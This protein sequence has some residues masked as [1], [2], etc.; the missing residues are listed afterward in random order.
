M[1]HVLKMKDGKLL[2]P[3]GIRDLLDAVQDM[4][5]RNSAGRSKAISI[6]MWRTL[7]TMKRS[8]TAWSRTMNA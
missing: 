5:A 8:M 2:T 6:P 4:P 3:F 1:P 7:M